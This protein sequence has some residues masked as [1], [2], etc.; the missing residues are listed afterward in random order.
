MNTKNN[1]R[2]IRL[3]EGITQQ[4]LARGSRVSR[5]TISGIERGHIKRPADET[6]L[7]I[8]EYLER[9]VEEIFFTPLVNH[10]K[11]KRATGTDS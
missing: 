6:I 10:V 11:Q 7:A 5:Q 1:L 3:I 8:A 4:E 9:E 2:Q